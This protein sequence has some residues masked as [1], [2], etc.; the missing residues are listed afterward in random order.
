MVDLMGRLYML[1]VG[2]VGWSVKVDLVS[3]A[4]LA[5][6]DVTDWCRRAAF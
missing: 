5:R 6:R 4:G 3:D 1:A 2:D